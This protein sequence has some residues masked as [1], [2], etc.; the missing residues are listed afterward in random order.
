MKKTMSILAL[1]AGVMFYGVSSAY[2]VVPAIDGTA[3]SFAG[4]W[5]NNSG[6]GNAYPYYLEVFDINEVL[7]NN[8]DGN[9]PDAYDIRRAVLLQELS[10]FSGDGNAANDGVYLLIEVY[11][12]HPSLVDPDASTPTPAAVSLAGDF[13]GDGIYDIFVEHEPTG[14]VLD[15]FKGK[16][17]KVTINNIPASIF[18]A[19]LIANGGSFTIVNGNATGTAC[20]AAFAPCT[21][22]TAIEYFFPAGKFGTPL[23]TPFP[24]SFV[25]NIL[26]D[27]AT[28]GADDE[29][30]GRVTLIPEPSSMLLVG[31]ALLSMLGVGGFRLWK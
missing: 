3:S 22:I 23:N 17:Q 24:S 9:I 11:A 2:A 4:E 19:D 10:S 18:N 12:N 29:I 26:Y 5:T 14:S 31:G 27:N 16:N 13:D 6:G 30:T 1:L 8:P 15:Q 7:G 28:R 20:A 25:G 21:P